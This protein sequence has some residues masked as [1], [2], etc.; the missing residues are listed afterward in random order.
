MASGTPVVTTNVGSINEVVKN[1]SNGFIGKNKD[2]NLNFFKNSLTKLINNK[3]LKNK[4][5]NNNKKLVRIN[6][7]IEKLV[8]KHLKAYQIST[9]KN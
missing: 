6:F 8:D 3:T 4:I 9:L 7:T 5:A 2:F 1:Y